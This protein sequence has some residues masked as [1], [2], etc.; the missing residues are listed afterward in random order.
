MNAVYVVVCV[1]GYLAL[2]TVATVVEIFHFADSLL[3]NFDV[4]RQ[5]INLLA[6]VAAPFLTEVVKGSAKLKS[7][8]GNLLLHGA[9]TLAITALA[10][11]ITGNVKSFSYLT[12]NF[13]AV[14]TLSQFAY[15]A[16]L[17]PLKEKDRQQSLRELQDEGPDE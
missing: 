5:I 6:G 1:F 9:V 14:F 7:P 4:E 13:V 17:T 11:L 10:L 15:R 3:A 8:L 2:L 16:V 12:T